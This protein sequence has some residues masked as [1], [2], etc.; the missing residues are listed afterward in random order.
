MQDSYYF[1]E[2]GIMHDFTQDQIILIGCVIA[3]LSQLSKIY[4]L[5]EPKTPAVRVWAKM[6]AGSIAYI[7]FAYIAIALSGDVQFEWL[8]GLAGVVGWLGGDS[9]AALGRT[10][11]T[12]LGIPL[13]GDNEPKGKGK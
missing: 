1:G 7:S 2:D 10:I 12:R 3:A 8:L 9:M 6:L 5:L 4:V 13:N 11:Q